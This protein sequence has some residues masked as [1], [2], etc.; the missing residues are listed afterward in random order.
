MND[1]LTIGSGAERVVLY[2]LPNTHAE[3]MLVAW[4]PASRLL[5]IVD[6]LSPGGNL[7]RIGSQEVAAMVRR[8]GLDVDRIVGGHGGLAPW[9]DVARAAGG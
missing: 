1:S 6:V 9:A 5:F 4:H 7:P 3:G 8:L 2:H